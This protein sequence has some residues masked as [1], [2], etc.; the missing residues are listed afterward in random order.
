MYTRM[1][2]LK[3]INASCQHAPDCD[4]LRVRRT[5]GRRPYRRVFSMPGT[6]AVPTLT[7]PL[8]DVCTL[9]HIQ[10]PT[11]PL[12]FRHRVPNPLFPNAYPGLENH[13]LAVLSSL[14]V[15]IWSPSGEK[16]TEFTA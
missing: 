14:P 9:G 4:A 12:P 7:Q 15:T 13:T 2:R 11:S 1:I 16:L 5:P 6:G 8:A 10:P 3:L